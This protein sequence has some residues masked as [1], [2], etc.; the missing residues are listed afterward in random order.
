[1]PDTKD[2]I[3][4]LPIEWIIPDEL[5]NKYATNLVIQNTNNEYIL[6]FFEIYPPMVLGTPEYQL[7]QYKKMKTVPAKCVAR[8][9][10]SPSN[11]NDFSKIIQ[12][13]IN[14]QNIQNPE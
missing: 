12:E 7:E 13:H 9:I 5:E 3:I 11:M 1:M 2:Q 10:V 14:K 6:S 4:D 8:I